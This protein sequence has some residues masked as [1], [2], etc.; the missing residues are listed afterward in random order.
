LKFL[1]N[2]IPVK[3]YEKLQKYVTKGDE[4]NNKFILVCFILNFI[5]LL[6]VLGANLYISTELTNHIQAYVIDYNNTHGINTSIFIFTISVFSSK[7]KL[8]KGFKP[9]KF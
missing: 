3:Y 9:I 7:D 4:Y 2:F 1:K 8:K 6:I 5:T